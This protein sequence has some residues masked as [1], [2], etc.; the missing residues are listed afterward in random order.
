MTARIVDY[1][2]LAQALLDFSHRTDVGN[3]QDYFIQFGEFRI[4]R[5]IFSK[6]MGDGVQ[7]MEQTFAGVMDPLTGFV[8]VPAGYLA[9]KDAQ[10]TNGSGAVATLLYKDPQW[11]YSNYPL[12]AAEG[13]P[14]YI[15]RDSTNF[16]F[17]PFP[18]DAYGLVGTYYGQSAPITA[19]NPTTW[20]TTFCPELLFASCMLE[21]QPFLR[22]Q[23][24]AGMWQDMY[25]AKLMG[26][27][28]L[29][30]SERLAAGAMSSDPE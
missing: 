26:L 21:L 6:N 10:A 28:D 14:K 18:D 11:I 19:L 23:D 13:F 8:P 30:R 24:G 17:G 9:M 29:D 4:Y 16:I 15:A 2:T 3:F 5:D 20:M 1:P 25:D 22:D 12:R 27:I 7:W